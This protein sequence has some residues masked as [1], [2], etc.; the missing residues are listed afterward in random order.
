LQ[1]IA[2]AGLIAASLSSIGNAFPAGHRRTDATGVWA[3]AVG[4]GIA[5]GPVAGAGLAAA[6]GWRSS[7]WLEAAAAAALVLTGTTLAESRAATKRPFDLPAVLTLGA[8][9]ACLTAGIIEGRTSWSSAA[10]IA[11]RRIGDAPKWRVRT[12]RLRVPHADLR[13]GHARPVPALL[14][15][16][17]RS[18][19]LVL[20]GRFVPGESRRG[21]TARG[22]AV[23][24]RHDDGPRWQHA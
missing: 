2:G 7:F 15:C 21:R 3:A 20:H 11:A 14:R 9:M 23:R 17:R 18:A 22:Y 13:S 16:G 10:T 24:D 4:G 19:Q 5:L 6:L 1:G 8:G 12:Q